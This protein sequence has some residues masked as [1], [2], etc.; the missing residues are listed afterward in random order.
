MPFQTYLQQMKQQNEE[1]FDE[2]LDEEEPRLKYNRLKIPDSINADNTISSISVSDKLIALGS[3]QGKVFILDITGTTLISEFSTHSATVN[4]LSID[5]HGE[6]VASASDDG[7][8]AIN[9]LYN[10]SDSV[11]YNY[12]RAV[13]AI[14]LEPDYSKKNT[15]QFASGG[16]AEILNISG[17][18]WFAST[19]VVIHSGEGPV[20]TIRWRNNFIAWANEIGVKIYDTIAQQKFAVIDRPVN[21]PRS[22]LFK[23]SLCWKNDDTLLIGW[24]DSVKL[25]VIKERSKMD[26]ASGLPKFCFEIFVQYFY[27][28]LDSKQT[29]L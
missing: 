22:D 4:E 28:N 19:N 9:S 25:G 6:F 23:C 24:A 17:K 26:I 7:K 15:K 27:L 18:G 1:D 14:A 8:V 21:S 12:K 10:P 3:H 11:I 16:M 29:L 5:S 2:E 13:K 20:Y